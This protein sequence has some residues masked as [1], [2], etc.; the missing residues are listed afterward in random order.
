MI[1][2]RKVRSIARKSLLKTSIF[3][4]KILAKSMFSGNRKNVAIVTCDLWKGRVYDDLLLQN[5]FLKKGAL[6]EI[7]SWQDNSIDW[8]K[9]DV[10]LIG[11]MWGYQNHLPELD[12]WFGKIDDKVVVN[13]LEMI[14]NNFNKTKQF[15]SLKKAKLPVVETKVVPID[16]VLNFKM[17]KTPFVV[18]PAISGGGENTFLVSKEGEL[19]ELMVILKKINKERELLVQ[20]YIPEI[21]DGELGVVIIEGEIVNAVK[22]FPGVLK[23]D[24]KVEPVNLKRLSDK[25]RD[26]AMKV[27]SLP[28]Y[29]DATYLRVDMVFCQN[30]CKIMEVEAFEPQLYYYLLRDE[31]REK[32]LDKMVSAVLGKVA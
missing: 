2:V 7:I 26:L 31:A 3:G 20:P 1:L 32:M 14:A 24:F 17:P 22:R 23:G 15:E 30:E 10:I 9:Y 28:E 8:E 13:S 11:S 25:A 19:E 18:K 12:K 16:G 21:S 4:R 5:W 6:A 29:K 27:C